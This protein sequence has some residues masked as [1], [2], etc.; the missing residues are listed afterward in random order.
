M[1]D[2]SAGFSDSDSVTEQIEIVEVPVQPPL[3]E[4]REVDV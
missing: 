3:P 2:R 4:K 1:S